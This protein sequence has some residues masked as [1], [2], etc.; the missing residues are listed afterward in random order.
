MSRL[1]EVDAL[2]ADNR[3]ADTSTAV[4]YSQFK[5][6]ISLK[7]GEDTPVIFYNSNRNEWMK[8][9]KVTYRYLITP[10]NN[11]LTH[12]RRWY[13]S[14]GAHGYVHTEYGD[15][16]IPAGTELLIYKL[17]GDTIRYMFIRPN[18]TLVD[19]HTGANII[20]NYPFIAV[21]PNNTRRVFEHNATTPIF[22][23]AREDGDRLIV[24]SNRPNISFKITFS[25]GKI[26]YVTANNDGVLT[27]I[28][29][30]DRADVNRWIQGEIL[31]AVASIRYT[32]KHLVHYMDK[33]TS[34]TLFNG[35]HNNSDS[36]LTI[37]GVH[38][39]VENGRNLLGILTHRTWVTRKI[40]DEFTGTE[41]TI[42][43]D[44][45]GG[46]QQNGTNRV[47]TMSNNRVKLRFENSD[48]LSVCF[49]L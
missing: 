10:Y 5:N 30:G 45:G 1:I 43:G 14:G 41:T 16:D 32:F 8:G 31:G 22:Y 29:K 35:I 42:N 49:T 15:T 2:D 20:G 7:G 12:T 37:A 33:D 6:R 40:I 25:N 48:A 46:N 26:T 9:R 13:T 34:K 39:R 17:N 11:I 47:F 24:V 23:A 44:S 38:H 36:N 4:W 19:V 3:E 21:L 18:G 28:D 27:F